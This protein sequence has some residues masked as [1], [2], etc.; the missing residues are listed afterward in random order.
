MVSSLAKMFDDMEYSVLYEGVETSKDEEKWQK[1]KY[2]NFVYLKISAEEIQN[3]IKDGIIK[4]E[5]HIK[6]LKFLQKNTGVYISDLENMT[7]GRIVDAKT[8]LE[9]NLIDSYG[10]FHD[11]L[12]F[13]AEEKL[14]SEVSKLKI[15]KH[16][17]KKS[18]VSKILGT[19]N[20]N[21][22]LDNSFLTKFF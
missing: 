2:G 1:E 16:T 9:N 21:V 12:K 22:T 13:L 17:A 14:N 10:T 18:F 6:V 19:C 4:S 8:A 20:F 3:L 7:D 11:A 15:V 5:K